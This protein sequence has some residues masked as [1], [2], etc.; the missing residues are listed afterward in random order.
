MSHNG[1][2]Q[3]RLEGSTVKLESIDPITGL[4]PNVKGLCAR[5]AMYLLEKNGLRVKITGRGFVQQQSVMPGSK[6]VPGSLI[7]LDLDTKSQPL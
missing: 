4:V 6:T 1:W 3:P 5:D 2:A 7:L